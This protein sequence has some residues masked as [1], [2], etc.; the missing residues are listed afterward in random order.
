VDISVISVTFPVVLYGF[1]TWSLTVRDD[2][3]K[4]RAE[5]NIC[6]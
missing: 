3:W 5:G 2:V 6:T 4:Q 1:K